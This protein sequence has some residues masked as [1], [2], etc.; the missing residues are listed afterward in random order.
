MVFI[1]VDAVGLPNP[2]THQQP[3]PTQSSSSTPNRQFTPPANTPPPSGGNTPATNAD[4]RVAVSGE[5]ILDFVAEGT[6]T[7]EDPSF[8]A[9]SYTISIEKTNVM[10]SLSLQDITLTPSPNPWCE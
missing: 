3:P 6:G 8:P 1:T 4:P 7:V 10:S 2:G 5:R 9:V